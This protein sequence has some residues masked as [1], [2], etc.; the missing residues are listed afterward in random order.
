MTAC[1]D[2]SGRTQPGRDAEAAGGEIRVHHAKG[3]QVSRFK[4]RI[5]YVELPK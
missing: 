5:E 1:L 4:G 3:P 2:I